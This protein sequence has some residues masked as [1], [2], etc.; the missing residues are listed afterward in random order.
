MNEIFRPNKSWPKCFNIY[1]YYLKREKKITHEFFNPLLLDIN[2]QRL[3]YKKI[4]ILSK[5]IYDQVLE[6]S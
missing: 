6:G 5:F 2:F 4:L 3:I 1:L